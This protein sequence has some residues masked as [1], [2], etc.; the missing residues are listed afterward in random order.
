MY[1]VYIYIYTH[2]VYIIT[3]PA[4]LLEDPFTMSRERL[5]SSFRG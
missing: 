5:G 1:H 4:A 2:M 3:Y